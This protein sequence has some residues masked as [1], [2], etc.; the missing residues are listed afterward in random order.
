MSG[1]AAA[2]FSR[3]ASGYVLSASRVSTVIDYSEDLRSTDHGAVRLLEPEPA[4]RETI[5]W[6]PKEAV[7]YDDEERH[8]GNAEIDRRLVAL[9]GD[10][11]DVGT[12]SVCDQ[13]VVTPRDHL[14]DDAGVPR[15]AG[16]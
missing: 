2:V 16:G 7:D 9:R 3:G 10:L 1:G 11:R 4:L 13:L 5:E 6:A 8:H 14:R 12:Q 15:P